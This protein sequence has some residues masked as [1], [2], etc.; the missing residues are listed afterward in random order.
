MC[1]FEPV[2]E[3][4]VEVVAA[5]AAVADE[6]EDDDER[7]YRNQEIGKAIAQHELQGK[8]RVGNGE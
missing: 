3:V 5:G 2:D 7:G 1:G 6:R 8:A 4:E